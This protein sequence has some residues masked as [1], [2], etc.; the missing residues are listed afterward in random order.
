MNMR[1][2]PCRDSGR[3]TPT[4]DEKPQLR[5][6]TQIPETSKYFTFPFR[7]AA[8]AGVSSP[9]PA[10]SAFQAGPKNGARILDLRDK[11]EL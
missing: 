1:Q 9:A 5:S 6:L 8:F 10:R 2:V 4:R 11:T 3:A 7:L